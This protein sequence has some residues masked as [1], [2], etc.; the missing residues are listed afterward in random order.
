MAFSWGPKSPGRF[1]V[2]ICGH[3]ISLFPGAES[4]AAQGGLTSS[5]PAPGAQT[6]QVAWQV[7]AECD[8]DIPTAPTLTLPTPTDMIWKPFVGLAGS[9]M[10]FCAVFLSATHK[11]SP[12]WTVK[13]SSLLLSFLSL[14]R[15]K[16][17]QKQSFSH[18]I[19]CLSGPCNRPLDIGSASDNTWID[20][21]PYIWKV[22]GMTHL[23]P[24]Q[25]LGV[26]L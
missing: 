23:T 4:S 13:L 12:L 16:G 24:S 14:E 19:H 22:L 10:Q 1:P 20:F 3:G 18:Q 9:L 15:K 8:T 26:Q 7:P 2:L 5:C 11:I 21:P 25:M 6:R 17:H